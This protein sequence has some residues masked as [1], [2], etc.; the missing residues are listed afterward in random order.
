[1]RS[2]I[3]YPAGNINADKTSK[4]KIRPLDNIRF[5]NIN[6]LREEIFRAPLE[7]FVLVQTDDKHLELDDHC[8]HRLTEVASDVDSTL[9][10]CYYRDRL[11]DGTIVDH[12]VIDYQP[13]SV[14]DDFDFGSLVLL[15]AADV[16]ASTEDMN[17]ES[18]MLDGGWYAL[19]LRVTMGKMI[20]MIPEYLYTAS[21]VDLRAS[22][23]KQ[24][25]YVDPRNREYQRQMEEVLT[26][27]LHEI[28]AA[29]DT[30]GQEK[31][32]YDAE[33]FPVE[34]SVIIPVRNR[35]R[36]IMDAVNSALS[37]E[38]GFNMN[39]IVVDNFFRPA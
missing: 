11:P 5:T 34:A 14:R 16:L 10:Y 18:Q 4:T 28:D 21:K 15:N 31:V 36:T 1:M 38:T 25:D 17:E 6:A 3:Y 27:H 19:R 20:A 24:H 12:P 35:A 7:Q 32:I 33:Q 23:K 22:G 39:V 8:I 9:T 37:Q 30:S 26:Q 29:V 2:R 13:G